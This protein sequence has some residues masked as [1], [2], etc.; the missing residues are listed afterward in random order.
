MKQDS[1]GRGTEVLLQVAKYRRARAESG[2]L[3]SAKK[4]RDLELKFRALIPKPS[5][6]ADYEGDPAVLN[7]WFEHQ[8]MQ[9]KSIAQQLALARAEEEAAKR[10]FGHEVARCAVTKEIIR[11]T[12]QKQPKL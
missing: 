4:A 2:L 6:Y 12:L 9:R 10:S 5:S 1:N 11:E 8:R 3:I 7:R